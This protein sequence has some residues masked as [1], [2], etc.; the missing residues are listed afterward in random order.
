MLENLLSLANI[1]N[2]KLNFI[3]WS[4]IFCKASSSIFFYILA[5]HTIKAKYN[6]FPETF[7]KVGVKI[8]ENYSVI[9]IIWNKNY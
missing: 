7:Q 6:F 8:N 2:I 9:A 4:L 3:V 5:L 1:A